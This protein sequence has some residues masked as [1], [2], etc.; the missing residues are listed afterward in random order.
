MELDRNIS[1]DPPRLKAHGSISIWGLLD[2][3]V[4]VTPLVYAREN[5]NARLVVCPAYPVDFVPRAD[6]T[7]PNPTGKFEKTVTYM[8]IRR[9][10]AALRGAAPFQ[11]GKEIKPREREI[12]EIDGDNGYI[13]IKGQWFDNLV[14]FDCW[15]TKN[16]EAKSLIEWFENYLLRYTFYFM[17]IG[18]VQMFYFRGGRFTWGTTEEEAMVRWRNPLK[19]RSMTYYFR[20]EKLWMVDYY[21]I[22]QIRISL[23]V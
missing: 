1:I 7:L 2:E 5:D 4:R 19:V 15:T 20:T 17:S 8:V 21:E 13:G 3:I 16:V 6:G 12:T 18:V 14:Q 9:E 23:E 10:P 22:E 11:G